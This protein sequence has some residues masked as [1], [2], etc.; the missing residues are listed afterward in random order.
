MEIGAIIHSALYALEYTEYRSRE[1]NV[2]AIAVLFT[3]F[4]AYWIKFHIFL[5]R[6]KNLVKIKGTW[7]DIFEND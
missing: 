7:K 1:T 2:N 6:R 5:F 3:A 4:V